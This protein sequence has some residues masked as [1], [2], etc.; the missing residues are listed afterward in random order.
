MHEVEGI[1]DVFQRHG[2]SDE[3][4]DVDLPVHVP[5]DD[6]RHVRAS[7]RTAERRAT[8]D[9]ACDQLEGPGSDLRPGWSHTDDGAFAPTF[10]TAF[11]RLAHGIDI[12]D[13]LEGVVGAPVC[14]I[15][16]IG[17]QITVDI[18]RIDKMGHAE[19]LGEFLL[20]RI[21]V[22]TDDHIGAYETRTLNDIE[23]DASQPEYDDVGTRLHLSSVD[24]R[25]D[26]GGHAASDV[27]DLV[28]RRV[29]PNLGHGDFGHDAVVGEGRSAHVV[30]QLLTADT[31]TACAVGHDALALGFA[32]GLAQ[33]GLA[34]KAVFALPTFGC[35]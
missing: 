13:A 22:D 35:V 30:I 28:E 8:P 17:R 32:N 20:A 2:V 29:L 26:A 4:V 31:E 3:V 6:P 34:R 15:H 19:F 23:T 14:Q 24:D 1:V 25:T 9:A 11:E 12:A 5:V 10:V 27:A 21:E 16:Q 33:V 18:V 7:L